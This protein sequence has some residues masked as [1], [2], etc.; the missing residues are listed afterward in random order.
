MWG[1]QVRNE[2]GKPGATPALPCIH[3]H[4]F[5]LPFPDYTS[6]VA[7]RVVRLL[8]GSVTTVIWGWNVNTVTF[9]HLDLIFG[10]TGGDAFRFRERSTN[11]TVQPREFS[12]WLSPGSSSSSD[13]SSSCRIAVRESALRAVK[14]KKK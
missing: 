10:I 11:G 1:L 8:Q 3:V 12:S 14:S 2:H 5:L 6:S 4:L 9:F 13:S 7:L